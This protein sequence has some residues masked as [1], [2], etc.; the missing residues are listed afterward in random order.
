MWG[1]GLDLAFKLRVDVFCVTIGALDPAMILRDLQPDARMAQ[2]TF[3]TITGHTPVVH[4]LGLGGGSGHGI[5]L[6]LVAG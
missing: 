5:Y 3:A 1:G 4:D 2:T 6:W